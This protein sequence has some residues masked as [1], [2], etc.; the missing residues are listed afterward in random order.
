VIQDGIGYC[1]LENKI[2]NQRKCTSKAIS[3]LHG[4]TRI[5]N[6]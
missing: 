1:S 4:D 3:V 5:S 6:N 2:R